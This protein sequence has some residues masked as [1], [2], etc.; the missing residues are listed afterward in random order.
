MRS[1]AFILIAATVLVSLL[2]IFPCH[3]YASD[4][5]AD[6][7]PYGRSMKDGYGERRAVATVDEA[8][9]VLKDYFSRK[10]VVIQDI[11]ERDW[12]FEAEVTDRS[13]KVI[14]RVI[15][16]KRTGRIRSIF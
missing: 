13:G 3:L 4:G 9:K 12:F 15:V 16:D 6:R 1:T 2:N 10:G 11:K 5:V 14:D 7:Y 8:R